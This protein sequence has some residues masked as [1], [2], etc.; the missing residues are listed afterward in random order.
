MTTPN[1]AL[2]LLRKQLG[3]IPDAL[4]TQPLFLSIDDTTVEKFGKKFELCS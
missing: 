1:G 3:V 2:L 4:L